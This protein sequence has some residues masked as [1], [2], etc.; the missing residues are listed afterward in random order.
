MGSH[1]KRRP[2][3][4]TKA[5]KAAGGL[6]ALARGLGITAQSIIKWDRVPRKRILQIERLTLV[7]REQLAPELYRS[8]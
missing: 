7:P 2:A 1:R 6:S 4:L 8:A 3:G 5:I